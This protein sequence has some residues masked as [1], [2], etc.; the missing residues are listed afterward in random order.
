VSFRASDLGL[1][2][3]DSDGSNQRQ[4]SEGGVQPTWSPSARQIAFVSDMTGRDQVYVMN[5]N[6][7][8]MRQLT[9]SS[10]ANTTRDLQPNSQPAR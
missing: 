9:T 2:L 1:W 5:I 8:G 7:P 10:G 4:L 6:G 3:M